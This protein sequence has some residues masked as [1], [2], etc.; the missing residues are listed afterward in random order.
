MA[1]VELSNDNLEQVITQIKF[2]D[3]PAVQHEITERGR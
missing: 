1:T 2:F 3:M